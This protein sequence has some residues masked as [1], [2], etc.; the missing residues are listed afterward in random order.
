MIGIFLRSEFHFDSVFPSQEEPFI[1]YDSLLNTQNK[2]DRFSGFC[3]DV[4]DKLAEDLHFQYD[5]YLVPDKEYG[6]K[7]NNATWTGMIGELMKKVRS[8]I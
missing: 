1:F 7:K 8:M 6:V 3:K 2:N 4:L 5:L